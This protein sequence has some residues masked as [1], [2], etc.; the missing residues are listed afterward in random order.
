MSFPYDPVLAFDEDVRR[1]LEGLGDA[2]YRAAEDARQIR[3]DDP[4]LS[5][6]TAVGRAAGLLYWRG[7]MR[8]RLERAAAELDAACKAAQSVLDADAEN[9]TKK[10]WEDQA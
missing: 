1:H 6:N 5:S 9:P 2:C 10:R 8:S 7:V 4:E 3:T